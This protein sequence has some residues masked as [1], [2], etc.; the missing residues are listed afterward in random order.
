MDK[1]LALGLLALAAFSIIGYGMRR[2]GGVHR[3]R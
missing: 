1:A 3:R 2:T